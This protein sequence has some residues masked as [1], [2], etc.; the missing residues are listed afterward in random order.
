MLGYLTT[1]LGNPQAAERLMR[2]IDRITEILQ[3]TP[4]IHRVSTKPF[5]A[6]Q[7]LREHFVLNYVI[8]Y[9]VEE[10]AVILVNLFHQTQDYES[11]RYWE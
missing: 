4:L 3:S 10:D 1:R 5:L 8:V 9:K 7:G 11:S 6:E 2:E